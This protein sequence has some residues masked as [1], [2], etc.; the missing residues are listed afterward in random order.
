MGTRRYGLVAALMLATAAGCGK[1]ADDP[2]ALMDG[3]LDADQAVIASVVVALEQL[4]GRVNWEETEGGAC[5]PEMEV[6]FSGK[7][8]GDPELRAIIQQLKKHEQFRYL[9]LSHTAVTDEGLKGLKELPNLRTLLL[10]HTAVTDAALKDLTQ[11][12]SLDLSD[13]GVTD[14]GVRELKTHKE[15]KW[16][17]LDNTKVTAAA[18][19]DIKA[20]LSDC[21]ITP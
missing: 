17:R 21:K 11:V 6:S 18:L 1:T 4:G 14:E 19:D 15:L 10:S 13:T 8:I 9:D 3:P 12:D 16:L 7:P 2:S 20:T 5:D